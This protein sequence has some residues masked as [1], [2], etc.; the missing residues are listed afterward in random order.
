MEFAAPSFGYMVFIFLIVIT[1]LVF[2]HEMGHY[3]VARLCGVRVESFSIGFGREIFGWND[4]HGTR[5]KIAMLPLGGYVKFFGD[6]GVASNPDGKLARMSEEE[7][8]VAFHYKPLYQR[9]AIVAAGPLINYLFAIVIFAIFFATLGYSFSPPIVETVVEASPAERAGLRPGDKILTIDGVEME[10]FSDIGRYVFIR[11]GE[12]IN[13]NVEREGQ[14]IQLTALLDRVEAEDQFNNKA[15]KGSLGIS[16][17]IAEIRSAG[18][19]EAIGLAFSR[20]WDV[21]ILMVESLK[22]VISGSLSVDQLGGPLKIAKFSGEAATMGVLSLVS[23]I[24][25]ISISLGFMNLLPVPM[26]DGGHLAFYAFEAVRGRP[27]SIRAQEYATLA[28][29]ACV[30]VFFVFVTVNDLKSFG[31]WDKLSNLFS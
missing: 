13:L 17:Q 4:K 21:Q 22:R 9:A 1:I 18:A 16:S 24:A 10:A 5:W 28:G 2:V 7:K 20:V 26:L 11:P 31:V 19:F 8:Q 29:L 12:E 27:A 30:L 25:F 15:E 23:F 6:A 3:L 14:D